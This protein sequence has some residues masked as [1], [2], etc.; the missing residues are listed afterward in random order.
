MAYITGEDR[1]QIT[2]FPEAVDDY[3]ATDNPVRVVEAFVNSLD[4]QELGFKRS[5][6]NNTGRPSYDPRDL[7]KLYLYGY[8]NRI[9]SSRRLESESGRNLELLWLLKKLKPDFKTIA[10]FR[11]DNSRALK[12]VFKRF[13]LL[14]K[15]W[16]LYGK[17]VIAVDGSKF[18]ASNSKRNNF[19]QKK[20]Q[21][22]LKY[23]DEKINGYLN[24]LDS[25]DHKEADIHVPNAEEIKKRIEELKN[26][27]E[28]YISM[29]Q[30]MEETGATEISTTDPDARLMSVNNNGIE[31]SYNVQT[32]V[33]SRPKT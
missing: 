27:K 26:R 15:N 25:N 16:G 5:E 18:R 3:I 12:E 2:L 14:C 30:Q 28:K 29:Q 20:I 17:E 9:R 7:L 23:I 31:V 21:R 22:H 13:A 11:K 33:D 4:M 6:P 8:L 19:N 24:E 32:A 10:D 1:N